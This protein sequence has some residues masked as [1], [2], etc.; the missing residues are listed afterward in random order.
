[1][2]NFLDTDFA[3]GVAPQQRGATSLHRALETGATDVSMQAAL[4]K[5]ANAD[6]AANHPGTPCHVSAG[7]GHS[8]G[9]RYNRTVSIAEVMEDLGL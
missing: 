2:N 7:R 9:K 3:R 5:A 6:T 4:G 1:M 8:F